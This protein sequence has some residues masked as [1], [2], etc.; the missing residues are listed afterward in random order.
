MPRAPIIYSKVHPYHVT[1]RSNNRDWFDLPLSYCYEVFTNVISTVIKRYQFQIHAFV[2]MDNHFHMIISTPRNNI[3]V[4]MRYFM[5]ETSRGIRL[6]S[7]R[8]NHVYGGRYRPCLITTEEYYAACIKYV[9]R[10]PVEA[11]MTMQVE[12]YPWSSISEKRS[13]LNELVTPPLLGHDG[14]LP[15][16]LGGQIKW[17]NESLLEQENESIKKALHRQEFKIS[18]D[19]TSGK[20]IQLSK[21]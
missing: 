12:E 9:Y 20:R 2:L 10:N 4:G 15:E 7:K 1:G 8:T 5:T 19:R 17:F 16:K 3:S 11:K 6:K 21:P 18:Q 13:R 14:L